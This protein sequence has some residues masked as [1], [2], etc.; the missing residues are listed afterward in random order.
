MKNK[1]QL[2]LDEL[3][4]LSFKEISEED[5][6]NVSGGASKMQRIAAASLAALLGCNAFV[7]PHAM[8]R[9]KYA[10]NRR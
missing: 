7:N 9:R 10:M 5:L 2:I 4:S 3:E 8:N 1:I 6:M